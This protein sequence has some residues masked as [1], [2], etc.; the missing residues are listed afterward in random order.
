VATA[1]SARSSIGSLRGRIAFGAL[2]EDLPVADAASEVVP[3]V[4]RW[5]IDDPRIDFI[6]VSHAVAADDGTV[7]IDP[8][9]LAPEALDAL[10]AV[11]AIC[12]SC[13]SHQRAIWRYRREL[14]APIHAPALSQTLE[15][16]PD[17]RYGDGDRLP[18]GLRAVFTPGAGTTQH[19]LLLDRDGGVAFVADLLLKAPGHELRFVRDRYLH[20]PEQARRSTRSLLELPFSVL[21]LAHGEPIVDDPQRAIRELL[22]RDESR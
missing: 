13:G 22:E 5:S 2:S 19:T 16:E 17:A 14:G 10:G 12:L 4:W 11:S 1:A 21:C 20:D 8:V 6:S 3:G 7:L 15:E 9:P 18:G